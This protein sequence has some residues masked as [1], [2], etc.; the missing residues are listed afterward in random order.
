MLV[1]LWLHISWLSFY[2]PNIL[3]AP[4]FII[5]YF[6]LA[7]KVHSTFCF[8]NS[9]FCFWLWQCVCVY[10]CV[11]FKCHNWDYNMHPN[12][13]SLLRITTQSF[14]QSIRNLQH[15]NSIPH[16]CSLW[17][18]CEFS[19]IHIHYIQQLKKYFF[20]EIFSCHI[21]K[22]GRFNISSIYL[23]ICHTLFLMVFCTFKLLM[24]KC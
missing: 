13:L 11:C 3:L 24:L 6:L 7:E 23:H 12:F 14:F 20:L 8:N 17:Y 4:C 10:V 2:L 19:S 9:T 1:F 5:L 15:C 16:P 22:S 21:K 18:C